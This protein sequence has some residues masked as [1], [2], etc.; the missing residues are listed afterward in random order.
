M[1]GNEELAAW[2]RTSL[3][4]AE[5][6]FVGSRTSGRCSRTSSV[7]STTSTK[8]PPGVDTDE[9]KP[10]PRA[11]ALAALLDEARR[12]PSNPGNANERLPDAGNAE[13]LAAFF[14]R[15]GAT[16]LYFGKLIHNKGVH[17][18]L[19]ALDGLDAKA[20]IVGFGDH[21][22]ELESLAPDGTLFTVRSSIAT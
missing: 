16:V 10:A 7:T 19:E 1:R 21:R 8:V 12:D 17:L 18:L 9:F 22:A 20:L 3:E 2:G 15:P 5:A 4:G 11:E 13:R 14:A 6:V